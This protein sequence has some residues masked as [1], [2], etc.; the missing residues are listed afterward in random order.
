MRNLITDFI[1]HQMHMAVLHKHLQ[2]HKIKLDGSEWAR[3]VAER[4][5]RDDHP[6]CECDSCQNFLTRAHA[7]GG[8]MAHE[9][10][11]CERAKHHWFLYDE[12]L[13]SGKVKLPATYEAQYEGG[14]STRADQWLESRERARRADV[15][16]AAHSEHESI[17]HWFAPPRELFE[18]E[19]AQEQAVAKEPSYKVLKD[20]GSKRDYLER[21]D[22][23]WLKGEE[24]ITKSPADEDED[25]WVAATSEIAETCPIPTRHP[26][27]ARQKSK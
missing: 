11:Q 1:D 12:G 5:H 16:A 13:Y 14:T 19:K 10:R 2:D 17:E 23:A 6:N 18:A 22:Q 21:V 9:R 15:P 8:L 25:F 7:F 24:P 3:L 26:P 20:I 27:R 4:M